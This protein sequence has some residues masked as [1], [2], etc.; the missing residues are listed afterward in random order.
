MALRL[1]WLKTSA[2]WLAC[3]ALAAAAAGSGRL[4]AASGYKDIVVGIGTDAS[5][6]DPQLCT[7]SATEVINKNIYNNLVRFDPN[8]K[9][10]PDLATSW[11]LAKDGLTW[12][13]NL[14]QGVTFH[15]GTPF[16]AAA[17]KYN[18]ERILDP[19]TASARRSVLAMIK[20]VEPVND[21]TVKIVTDYPCGSFL[22]QLAHP[23][24]AMISPTAAAKWGV[25][26]FGLNPCGTGPLK[27]VQW[28][29]SEKLEFE[30]FDHYWEGAP[31]FK[32]LTY[33]I[34]P[35]DETRAL[36]LESG[37]IDVAFRLPVT[38]VQRLAGNKQIGL[39]I[40]PTIMTMYVALN[41]QRGPLKD[42]NVRLALNLAVNK[43]S[44]V[45]D[46]VDDLATV[47]DSV[48][49]PGVW[50]YAKIGAYPYDP[51]QARKLLAKAGYPNGFEFTLWT[52]V[53]RYLMD[54]QMAEAIQAQMAA[55]GV[56]MK[57]QTWDFQA[58][59]SEVKKGQFDAVLLGWSASSAD[60]DQAMFPVFE[61]TQFPP[62]S[63]RAFYK[64]AKVDEWLN[65]ARKEVNPSK[66][67]GLYKQAQKQI[68]ADAPW[69]LLCYPKQ[70]VA[71][72]YGVSGIEVLPTEHVLFARTTK[73]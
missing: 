67:A 60:A 14:R 55:V 46:V 3:L 68:M 6:L 8:M 64:N 21:L 22:Y 39:I 72:R 57:I 28:E 5:T 13:F 34:V 33:S 10:V 30:A 18:F 20:T 58:L 31:K 32:T 41:N 44:I 54:K 2:R 25:Q 15:D 51:A 70:C 38:E 35:E 42:P 26:K 61:S 47:A 37:Q 73:K 19:K 24:A 12:T 59:M 49:P 29:P 27:L 40:T 53:G 52:P 71:Y 63:N 50:G 11:S 69:I 65:E 43:N 16:N 17:V 9:L 62:N 7:D 36:L 4:S 56:K 48:I 23:V 45:H 1:R 66:R